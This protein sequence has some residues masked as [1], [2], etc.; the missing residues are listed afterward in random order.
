MPLY[1]NVTKTK[2]VL[3][4]RVIDA[5]STFGLPQN[6]A[7]GEDLQYLLQKGMIVQ[8]EVPSKAEIMPSQKPFEERPKKADDRSRWDVL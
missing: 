3:N 2:I 7:F 6:Y 8:I 5:L 4:G 1:R